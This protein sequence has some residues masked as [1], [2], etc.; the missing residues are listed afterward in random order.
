MECLQGWASPLL[1][2]TS[3]RRRSGT[4]ASTFLPRSAPPRLSVSLPLPP[5][6]RRPV[7]TVMMSGP[8]GRP[9]WAGVVLRRG[10]LQQL[11]LN[12][13]SRRSAKGLVRP[14]AVIGEILANHHPQENDDDFS[15]GSHIAVASYA[16]YINWGSHRR[17]E[18][19]YWAC[20]NLRRVL[21]MWT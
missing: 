16:W 1:H 7:M 11:L 8:G 19:T 18:L 6:S 20:N 2:R 5:P 13:R 17:L 15:S 10:A 14:S 3:A 21:F 12:R 4:A 9:P